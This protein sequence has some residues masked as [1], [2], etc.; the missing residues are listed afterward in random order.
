MRINKPY[1]RCSESYVIHFGFFIFLENYAF[2][3]HGSLGTFHV[4]WT[5]MLVLQ[6][7]Y[8]GTRTPCIRKRSA[9]LILQGENADLCILEFD[10]RILYKKLYAF[11]WTFI[12][13]YLK[14]PFIDFDIEFP[15]KYFSTFFYKY[16]FY[17]TADYAIS[18]GKVLMFL[19]KI[20]FY[21]I[22]LFSKCSKTSNVFNR[23]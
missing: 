11:C 8:D 16:W 3:R 10:E 12:P 18:F 17:S 5:R 1:F 19:V 9:L 20:Y 13:H 2:F 23:H 7:L 4:V 22:V 15:E 21:K 14:K 6:S